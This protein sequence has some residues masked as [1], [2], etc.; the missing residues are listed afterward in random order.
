M[1]ES[2][3]AHIALKARVRAGARPVPSRII[4]VGAAAHERLLNEGEP[5][6]LRDARHDGQQVALVRPHQQ[7]EG[8]TAEALKAHIA[9]SVARHRRWREDEVPRHLCVNRAPKGFHIPGVQGPQ[10]LDAI[11]VEL[12]RQV[13]GAELCADVLRSETAEQQVLHAVDGRRLDEG[14]S[15]IQQLRDLPFEAC[16]IIPF[17]TRPPARPWAKWAG[18]RR[19]ASRSRSIGGGAGH[20]LSRGLSLRTAEE[21]ESPQLGPGAP[22]AWLSLGKLHPRVR[23]APE[24][25]ARA[26]RLRERRL[27]ATG[28][29]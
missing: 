25:S 15:T 10:Q 21:R 17:H 23:Q 5:L 14:C 24:R 28:W 27:V 3:H 19:G 2:Q 13:I 1:E 7:C 11:L 4:R 29:L 26:E 20:A 16:N 18:S 12:I 9:G 8:R 6:L 22:V